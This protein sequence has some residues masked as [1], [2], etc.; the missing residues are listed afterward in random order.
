MAF[1]KVEKEIQLEEKQRAK[2]SAA[3]I[4]NRARTA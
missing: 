3:G 1:W 4:A 2:D